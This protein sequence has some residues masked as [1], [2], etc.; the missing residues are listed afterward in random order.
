MTTNGGVGPSV[1]VLFDETR[2]DYR[3]PGRPRPVRG[4][5]AAVFFTAHLVRR[6]A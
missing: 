1:R 6:P 3:A 2:E 5:A 4:E